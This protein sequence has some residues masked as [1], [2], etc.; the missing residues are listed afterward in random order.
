M[1][2]KNIEK[3]QNELDHCINV[4]Q[5]IKKELEK[6]EKELLHSQKNLEHFQRNQVKSA[7]KHLQSMLHG[8]LN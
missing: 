2:E 8:C 6:K 5:N 7:E 1:E 3:V 4:L